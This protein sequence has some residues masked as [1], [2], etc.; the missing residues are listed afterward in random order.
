MTEKLKPKHSTEN[1]WETQAGKFANSTKGNVEF[2]LP[3]FGATKIVT[4][5]CH[6]TKSS[7]S[8][9]NMI[10]GRD[11]LTAL[12]LDLKFS[13]NIIL[14][15]DGPYK[16]CS[17]P[18]VDVS[19]YDFK[20]LTYNKVKPEESFI[21]TYVNECL[22]SEGTISSTRRIRI[23]LD[24]KYKNSDLNKVMDKQFQHLSPKEIERLLQILEN[25]ES[26]FNGTLGTWKHLR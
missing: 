9:Y 11:L 1:T 16:G 21:D 6:I 24:V 14:E 19:T 8:R 2:C 10:L 12:G 17:A 18:M 26:L 25:S 22:Q 23:I 4:R 20:H 5:K 15:S 7:N 3:E 13:E